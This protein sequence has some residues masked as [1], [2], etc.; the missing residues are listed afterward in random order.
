Q[1]PVPA[2]AAGPPRRRRRVLP[3]LLAVLLLLVAAGG[4]GAAWYWTEGPGV[5]SAMPQVVGLPEDQA[6]QQLSTHRLAP[7]VEQDYS[8]TVPAGEVIESSAEPGTELRHGTEVQL[9]VSRGPERYDV[10]DLTGRT[11]EEARALLE[12]QHLALGD[13]ASTWHEEVPEG[14]VLSLT[15]EA[16]A[17]VKPG[18]EVDVVLSAGPEPIDVP[19][20]VGQPAEQA[21]QALTDAG[22]TVEVEQERV[23]HDEVPE[24]AVTAQSPEGGT[25]HRGDPVTLTLSKGPE[26]VEVP[27]V[28]GMQWQRAK[29]TLE[30]LGLTA[31]RE[32]LA[33]GYFNTV[34]FQSVDP[35]ERLPKGE[36]VTLTVL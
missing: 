3:W 18:T 5:H 31:E 7:V 26:T 19:Q 36:T 25:G 14:Q 32:D 9:V 22:F 8:E 27:R 28:I 34:R 4:A 21:R 12:E 33:G 10:P 29:Q 6:R 24:G 23:F 11:T 1:Q 20:V 16:G 30:E 35:G 15:P 13:T 17:S 2:A